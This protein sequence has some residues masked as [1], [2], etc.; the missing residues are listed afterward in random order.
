MEK[1]VLERVAKAVRRNRFARTGRS[2][3]DES[4]PP[5][6]NELDDARAAVESLREIDG[7]LIDDTI[8][9]GKMLHL[10]LGTTD[11]E[12][13]WKA[14]CDSILAESKPVMRIGLKAPLSAYGD[15]T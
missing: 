4:V 11:F 10:D 3:F 12:S 13:L 6:E 2:V 5:T 15:E 1:T 9:W 8:E 14:A 7:W